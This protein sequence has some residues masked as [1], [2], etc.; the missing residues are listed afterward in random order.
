MPTS[1]ISAV[2][3]SK[4]VWNRKRDLQT[5]AGA[6]ANGPSKSTARFTRWKLRR[7]TNGWHF[8]ITSN[9]GV[10]LKSGEESRVVEV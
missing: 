2:D 6:L 1:S 9:Y 3:L 5:S 8:H 10:D 7:T 4:I